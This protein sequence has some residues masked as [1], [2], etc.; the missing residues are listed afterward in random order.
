[1]GRRLFFVWWGL[2]H[3][4]VVHLY[5]LDHSV[6]F[7]LSCLEGVCHQYY[8]LAARKA[9]NHLGGIAVETLRL[10]VLIHGV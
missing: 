4:M 3:A 6:V 9:L 7:L 8:V 1:M 10:V 2:C 5:C